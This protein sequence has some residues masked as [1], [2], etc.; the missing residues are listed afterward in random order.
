VS[1]AGHIE[2]STR[3]VGDLHAHERKR[4]ARLINSSFAAYGATIGSARVA[5]DL[6][7]SEFDAYSTAILAKAGDDLVGVAFLGPLGGTELW[8]KLIATRD[9]SRRKD[10]SK[11]IVRKACRIGRA[12]GAREIRGDSLAE[13]RL[14]EFFYAMG[15]VLARREARPSGD[16]GG[17]LTQHEYREYIGSIADVEDA[18]NSETLAIRKSAVGIGLIGLVALAGIFLPGVISWQG[19]SF[20]TQQMRAVVGT[21]R[22]DRGTGAAPSRTAPGAEAPMGTAAAANPAVSS[23]AVT[24]TANSSSTPVAEE[25]VVGPFSSSL[26]NQF[27][28]PVFLGGALGIALLLR[29]P[30][31]RPLFSEAIRALPGGLIAYL[32]YDTPGIVRNIALTNEVRRVYSYANWDVDPLS[33]AYQELE[34]FAFFWLIIIVWQQWLSYEAEVARMVRRLESRAALETGGAECELADLLSRLFGRW[35]L[36]TTVTVVVFGAI[37]LF[38]LETVGLENDRRYVA[39]AF[40]VQLFGVATL[41][42]LSLPLVR[43]LTAFERLRLRL[44]QSEWNNKDK[45]ELRRDQM[46]AIRPVSPWQLAGSS[47]FVVASAIAPLAQLMT[48]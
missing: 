39:S 22:T 25:P 42:I 4:I 40:I 43:A 6:S 44:I 41:A 48:G 8:I 16:S 32:I 30:G 35:Q 29:P 34:T 47:L 31:R 3:P 38:F 27:F 28:W 10:V 2:I 13:F 23:T 37:F 46:A 15:M 14:D 24:G 1:L 11:A 36:A 33:F 5:D 12:N 21:L 17:V 18:A 26:L 45:F 20:T 19:N 9:G 7:D